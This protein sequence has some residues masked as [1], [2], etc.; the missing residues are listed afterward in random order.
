MDFIDLYEFAQ[1]LMTAR[2]ASGKPST[3]PVADLKAEL[4]AKV[5][6]LDDINFH[7]IET[8]VGDPKGHYECFSDTDDRWE[9]PKSWVV[10]ITYDKN[11]SF[12]GQRF[13]WCKELMHIFDTEGGSV[14]TDPEYRGLLQEIELKPIDP[15]EAYLSENQAKW[16][17]L[18]ILCPKIQRDEMK[19][20]ARRE[21]LTPYDVALHLRIPEVI[22]GS[23][24]SEYYERY[25]EQ[26]GVRH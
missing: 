19:E 20:R 5:P 17:A 26:F 25:F 11:L 18:L 23:L 12:C 2:I 6:W 13:V 24:F 8:K 10:L 1:G 22:V 7:P 16:L 15:S 14:K 9:D 4:I 3:V 21:G